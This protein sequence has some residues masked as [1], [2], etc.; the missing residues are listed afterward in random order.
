MSAAQVPEYGAVVIVGAGQ[1]GSEVATELRAC[2]YNGTLTLVHEEE[3]VPY[4][5]PPLSK[6]YLLGAAIEA[7]LAIRPISVYAE[8]RIEILSGT[9]DSIDRDNR[10]VRLHDG[11]ERSYDAVIL[12][13]GGQPRRLAGG[14]IES[15]PNVHYLKT[16]PDAT[17]LKE[18]LRTSSKLVIVGGGYIGLEAAAA[19]RQLGLQVTVL[20]AQPR[21]LARVTSEPVSDF[22]RRLH[23]SR[24][25][26]IRL[27]AQIVSF[28]FGASGHVT[29]VNL[30]DGERVACDALLV[31][32]GQQPRTELAEAAGLAVAEGVLVDAACRSSDACILAIGD[33][34]RQ[35]CGADRA[36][37]RIESVDNALQQARIAAAALTGQPLPVRAA[38]WFWSNQFDARLQSVG[39]YSPD[40]ER[41]VRGDPQTDSSFSVWY[42][43]AGAL[44]AA[45]VVSSPRDFAAARKLVGSG[46]GV[47]PSMLA[48]TSVPLNY[49]A[50]GAT[51]ACA[52]SRKPSNPNFIQISV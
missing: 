12:A 13:T 24:G 44:V 47:M 40:C 51:G 39:I 15:A 37:R 46:A 22:Y 27:A 30:A 38:P 20:E 34:A 2:G 33:C 49:L 48:D 32:I 23:E 35:Q 18:N 36:L 21:L 11:R 4:S 50:T 6:A 9:V 10:R 26:D 19:A 41:V 5:R 16:L 28:E 52:A 25:V 42:L 29:A 3:G 17:A 45:D 14:D 8:Q 43:R 31:G 7:D 1:A